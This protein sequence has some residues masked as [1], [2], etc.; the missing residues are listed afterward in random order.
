M[1][2]TVFKIYSG[3]GVRGKHQFTKHLKLIGTQ[4]LNALK[5]S[6]VFP[7]DMKCSPAGH[8]FEIGAFK[9][10]QACFAK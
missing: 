4:R 10:R 8:V 3:T 2:R 9:E 6:L 1:G 5:N 7:D